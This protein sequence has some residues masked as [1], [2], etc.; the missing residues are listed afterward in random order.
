MSAYVISDVEI[1]DRA[2]IGEYR[3]LAQESIARY[4]GRYLARGGA[5]EAIEGGWNPK[6]LIIVEFPDMERAR[7]WYR[8]SEYA[9]ALKVRRRALDR[10]LILVDGAR[11]AN[12]AEGG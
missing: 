2:L 4:G 11:S 1:L 5:I 3:I 6:G 8:S 10:R 9:K 7:A 12:A